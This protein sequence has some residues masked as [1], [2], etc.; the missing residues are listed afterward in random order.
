MFTLAHLKRK[1][2][3]EKIYYF[4]WFQGGASITEIFQNLQNLGGLN[5][6]DL[7]NGQ[8]FRENSDFSR[9]KIFD[10]VI[11]GENTLFRLFNVLLKNGSTEITEVS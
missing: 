2:I 4:I 10:S 8:E 9:M 5:I 1:E 7:I 11:G 3:F 6:L